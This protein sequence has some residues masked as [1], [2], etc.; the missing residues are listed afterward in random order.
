MQH[1]PESH[2]RSVSWSKR[3][4]HLWNTKSQFIFRTKE[5][6]HKTTIRPIIMHRAECWTPFQKDEQNV[7]VIQKKVTPE[8]DLWP[9]MGLRHLEKQI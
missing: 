1:S 4:H 8:Q 6:I 5:V 2:V 9:S 3:T 7:D